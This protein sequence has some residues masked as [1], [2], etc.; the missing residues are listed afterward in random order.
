VG[1]ASFVE[2]VTFGALLPGK[3]HPALEGA[4]P[5]SG[6]GLPRSTREGFATQACDLFGCACEVTA[7]VPEHIG[8][9]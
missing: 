8:A 2:T 7:A 6:R 5:W 9:C 3:D 4:F 1:E